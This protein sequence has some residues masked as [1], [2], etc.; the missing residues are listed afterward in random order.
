MDGEVFVCR[1]K[2]LYNLQKQ[3]QR[4]GRLTL[5]EGGGD[6]VDTVVHRAAALG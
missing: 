3:K 6:L 5:M 4:T 1:H 2:S